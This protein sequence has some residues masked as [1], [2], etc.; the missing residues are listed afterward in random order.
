MK[1]K[2]CGAQIGLDVQ[3]CPYC[4]TINQIAL[5]R[6]DTLE[7][8]QKSNEELEEKV[9]KD[10]REVMWYRLHKRFNLVLFMIILSIIAFGFY[11]QYKE[12]HVKADAKDVAIMKEY[13]ETGNLEELYYFMTEND[14]MVLDE[15]YEY[16]HVA[17]VWYSYHSARCDFINAY[18]DYALNGKYNKYMLESCIWEGCEVLTGHMSYYGGDLSEH[19]LNLIEGF[20]EEIYMLF[21]GSLK[22]PDEMLKNLEPHNS[23]MRKELLEYVL[24]VLPYE[25]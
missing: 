7:E 10:S 23:E 4:G 24:G 20:Q 6:E 22:I 9:I 11:I 2:N 17:S 16:A 19:S 13:Y 1:C 21:G 25:E 18:D 12:N 8:M 3:K 14:F 15:Y 5:K